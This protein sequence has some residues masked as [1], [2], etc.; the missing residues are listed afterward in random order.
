MFAKMM[1]LSGLWFYYD[2][3]TRSKLIHKIRAYIFQLINLV[4]QF[5][6]V[7]LGFRKLFL[8]SSIGTYVTGMMIVN[9][10]LVIFIKNRHVLNQFVYTMM[11]MLKKRTR[12]WEVK[13]FDK[14]CSKAWIFINFQFTVVVIFGFIIVIF[15]T[16]YDLILLTFSESSEPFFE[17]N[18]FTGILPEKKERSLLLYMT[19]FLTYYQ[20][21]VGG[22]HSISL[23]CMLP[24]SVAYMS[25][26]LRIISKRLD[27]WSKDD[28]NPRRELVLKQ[29]I[30][31]HQNIL[32]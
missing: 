32:A 20:V 25:A 7:K 14:F 22:L 17:L 30:Q 16:V 21:F 11:E 13:I 29:I 10:E 8:E 9:I 2:V 1:K 31:D 23:L 4:V 5:L 18:F 28:S 12:A 24:A 6:A 19:L 26:E 27:F 15:P 3:S